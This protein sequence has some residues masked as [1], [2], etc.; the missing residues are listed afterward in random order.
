MPTEY[1]PNVEIC[2]KCSHCSRLSRGTDMLIF[3]ELPMPGSLLKVKRQLAIV[4]QSGDV[5]R[6][7]YIP[8]GCP[9]KLE[10]IVAPP[11]I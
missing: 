1:V 11:T 9:Y 8:Q 3:C 4:R 6:Q 10:H 5:E 7:K 2:K